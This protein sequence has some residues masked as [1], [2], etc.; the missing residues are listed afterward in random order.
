MRIL[1]KMTIS[2]TIEFSLGKSYIQLTWWGFRYGGFWYSRFLPTE[3]QC[4]Y[5]QMACYEDHCY[6]WAIGCGPFEIRRWM[7]VTNVK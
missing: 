3:E 1:D 4:P 7:K 5:C 2:K 6:Y